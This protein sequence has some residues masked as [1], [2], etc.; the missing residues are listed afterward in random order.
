MVNLN[1]SEIIKLAGSREA[2]EQAITTH[3]LALRAFAHE[4]GKPRPVSH[5]AVEACIKREQEEGKPDTYVPN[6]NIIDDSPPPPTLEEKKGVAHRAIQAAEQA[7]KNNILPNAKVRLAN[8]KYSIAYGKPEDQRSA[9]EKEDIA[10][11]L[12]VHKAWQQIDLQSAQ[13]ES[14]LD[15]LDEAGVDSWKPPTFG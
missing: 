10:S 1:L 8:I 5:P 7:A 2:F 15:D 6:Y 3:I 14:D 11:L 9:E 4:I 12:L 13:A